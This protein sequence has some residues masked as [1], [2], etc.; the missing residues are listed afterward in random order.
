MDWRSSP[1]GWP[2]LH[3]PAGRGSW[4][5]PAPPAGD[6]AF[7]R[8]RVGKARVAN[9]SRC[10]QVR[11]NGTTY[12]SSSGDQPN[13]LTPL[14]RCKLGS[15]R[16]NRGKWSAESWREARSDHDVGLSA[17]TVRARS[18]TRCVGPFSRSH[19]GAQHRGSNALAIRPHTAR[20]RSFA[21]NSRPSSATRRPSAGARRQTQP[22]PLPPSGRNTS[23]RPTEP[24]TRPTQARLTS[25]CALRAAARCR[26]ACPGPT[27]WWSG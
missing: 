19:V 8:P 12:R 6:V 9:A 7:I 13:A 1:A 26:A 27:G 15:E 3:A 5:S 18:R 20:T 14:H 16:A 10:T 25:A 4:R 2:T 22:G 24:R 17:K 11:T 21:A 23:G